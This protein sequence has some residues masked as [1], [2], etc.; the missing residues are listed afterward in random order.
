MESLFENAGITDTKERKKTLLE[1]VD[2]QTE[3]EWLGFDSYE[4]E[5]SWEDFTKKIKESYPEAVDDTG[6]IV[7]LEQI[8]KEHACLS[9]SNIVEIHTLMRKFQHEAKKLVKVIGNGFLVTKFL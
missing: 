5:T 8:C 2:A 1:Y 3:E 9:R 4:N 6:S 7:N